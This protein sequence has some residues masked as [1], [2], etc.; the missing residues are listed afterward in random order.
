MNNN[1]FVK[2][3]LATSVSLILGALSTPIYAAEADETGDVEVIQVTG[4]RGSVIKAMD[5]KR[6][7]TGIVDAISAEDIGKFPDTNLAESLQRISGVSIDRNNGEG[8]KVTV[9]G[10]GSARNL[11]TLNGRQLANTTGDRSFNFDNLA[12][13]GISGLEVFKTSYAKLPTGGLGATINLQTNEPLAIGEDKASVSVK[14]LND[15]SA[16]EGGTTPELSGIYSTVSDDEKFGISLS[17]NLS[18]IHI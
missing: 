16:L 13:E 5:M 14:V 12:A 9:R 3:K 1:R 8:Q 18:L 17:V 6:S 11:V 7:S 2:T 4:I 15:S 10:F